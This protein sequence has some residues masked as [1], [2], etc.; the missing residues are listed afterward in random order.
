LLYC[1]SPSFCPKPDPKRKCISVQYQLDIVLKK[2]IRILYRRAA[3]LRKLTG[4][5]NLKSEGELESEHMTGKEVAQMTFVRP[6]VLGF[7][8]PIVFA[9]NIYIALVY[10]GFRAIITM[11]TSSKAKLTS[12]FLGILY[13][14][15]ESYQVVFVQGYGFNLGE[16]GLAFMGQFVGAIVGLAILIPYVNRS[17]R[18]RLENGLESECSIYFL[19]LCDVCDSN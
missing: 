5:Q 8:E 2:I 17:L 10:G 11:T 6:F 4:N 1:F 19:A 12:C 3:R 18:P 9:W 7:T 16:N 13:I 15:I 14:W